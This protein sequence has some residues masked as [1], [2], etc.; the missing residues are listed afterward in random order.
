[1]GKNLKITKI[2]L[3]FPALFVTGAI[4]FLSS[5]SILPKPVSIFGFDKLQHMAA[6]A[7][8]SAAVC[9]WFSPEFRQSR[10][11]RALLIAVLAGSVYGIIDEIHQYYVPNRDCNVWDWLADTIGAFLG[12]GASLK[13]LKKI[14]K[15]IGQ[16]AG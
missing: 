11:F 4:W 7:V 9:L 13:T 3:K 8:L 16:P 14:D 6:Y 2:L 15:R 1:M 12:A 5:Q 10:P